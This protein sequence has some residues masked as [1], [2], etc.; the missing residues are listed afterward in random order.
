MSEW[1]NIGDELP[2]FY[3][4]VLL[5][6]RIPTYFVGRFVYETEEDEDEDEFTLEA[7]GWKMTCVQFHNQDEEFYWRPLPVPPVLRKIVE[8]G[9]GK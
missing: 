9:E 1:K 8:Q 6:S 7:R 2:P 4:D 3:T 5:F